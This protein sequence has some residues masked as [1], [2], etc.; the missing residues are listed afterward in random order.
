MPSWK[1]VQSA[2]PGI[3]EE[4]YNIVEADNQLI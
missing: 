2:F 1:R 4:F 3:L